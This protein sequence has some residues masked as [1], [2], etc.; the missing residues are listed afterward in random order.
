M[1]DAPCGL[2]PTYVINLD[3]DQ[4][5][6]HDL[7]RA[8]TGQPLRLI[9]LPA[10]DGAAL[11]AAGF[12]GCRDS[13]PL[14]ARLLCPRSALGCALSHR[15]VCRAFLESAEDACLV[16]E[17]D[18]R[19]LGDDGPLALD[20]RAALWQLIR[21][22]PDDWDV[23]K[24]DYWPRR[25]LPPFAPLRAHATLTTGAYLLSRSGAAK[26]LTHRV[27]YHIDTEWLLR[28]DLHVYHAPRRFQQAPY[29]S[30]NVV[31][32]RLNPLRLRRLRYKMLRLPGL[33]LELSYNDV[34]FLGL[35]ALGGWL[36]LRAG[37]P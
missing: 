17:D 28:R 14:V 1:P 11:A 10:V 7:K 13:I 5:R 6:L 31:Q 33:D 22:A 35:V 16:L 19:P 25:P 36:L 24:L 15:R 3:R 26:L 4:A 21:Q 8:L 34:L 12:R 32:H 2:F 37:R 30:T 27:Y 29:D 9:R 18:S 23:I 20:L